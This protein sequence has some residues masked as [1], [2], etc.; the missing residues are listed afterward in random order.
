MT[1]AA[2][3]DFLAAL[4]ALASSPTSTRA[5][6]YQEQLHSLLRRPRRDVSP[7]ALRAALAA[8]LDA[9]VFSDA[10][11]TGGGLVVGRQVLEAFDT[12]LAGPL[13]APPAERKDE[14][15]GAED[16][17]VWDEETRTTLFED[18][19]E[20]VQPRVLSFEEQVSALMEMSLSSELT[21][22]LSR[23][24]RCD[25]IWPTCTSRR[26]TGRRRQGCCRASH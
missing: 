10:N 12:A 22:R 11:S 7:A 15:L 20:K 19:I 8:F 21:R 4:S 17:A 1:D 24:R 5:A 16:P 13:S 23:R 9:A 6:A 3:A 18:A 14:E 2:P 25:C 26:K